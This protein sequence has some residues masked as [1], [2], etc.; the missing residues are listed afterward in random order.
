MKKFEFTM[1]KVLEYKSHL[2][3][4]EKHALAQMRWRYDTLLAEIEAALKEY[5]ALKEKY[6]QICAAGTTATEMMIFTAHMDDFVRRIEEMLIRLQQAEE[7][8]ERQ[9]NLLISVSQEKSTIGKLRIRYLSL[10]RAKEKKEQEIFI[11]DF[12]AN[13]SI[14]SPK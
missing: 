1:Q 9:R 8:I 14:N 7:E 2:E 4:R 3:D 13:A 5:E 6:R 12:V 10:Y 11:N